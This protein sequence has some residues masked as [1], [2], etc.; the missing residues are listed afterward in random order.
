VLVASVKF[1]GSGPLVLRR[2]VFLFLPLNTATAF[3]HTHTQIT[4]SSVTQSLNL[5]K[6][7]SSYFFIS[8]KTFFFQDSNVCKSSAD[9]SD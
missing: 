6:N 2:G 9:L 5:N 8:S 3:T 4:T 7:I 1:E